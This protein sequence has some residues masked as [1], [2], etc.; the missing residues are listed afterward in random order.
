MLQL[1]PKEIETIIVLS[2][3]L[4]MT[5]AGQRLGV[6]RSAVSQRLDKIE[7]K[8]GY[9]IATRK[10]RL[11]LT[12]E[13]KE[14]AEHCAEMQQAYSSLQTKLQRLKEPRLDIMADEVLLKRDLT[15]VTH[16]MLLNNPDLKISLHR[17]SFS[18]IIRCVL[19]GTIDAGLIA[20]NPHVPGLRIVPYRI[21][22]VCLMMPCSH[23]LT[24]KKEMPF[25]EA[26]RWPIIHA[27]T[28]EH[29]IPIIDDMANKMGIKLQ[30][31]LTCPS[32]DVQAHYAANTDI[33]IALTLES[34]ALVYQST[35]PI[36]IIHLTDEWADNQLY[37]CEREIGGNSTATT[38]LIQLM[39][40]RHSPV[41]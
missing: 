2:R 26:I 8:I 17:G 16:Q 19:N 9:T 14:I 28:L 37:I 1:D 25:S 6:S 12:R 7:D 5:A 32:F 24:S 18:E 13:G 31:P 22:R 3:E 30:R 38:E 21:E 36:H 40:A 39:V 35:H 23:P 11:I 10:G 4:S 41:R 34:A 15:L 33:A 20:G 27:D 29:I